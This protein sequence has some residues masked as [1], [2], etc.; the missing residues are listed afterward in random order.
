MASY[1]V[2]PCAAS[3][4]C[5]AWDRITGQPGDADHHTLCDPCLHAGTFAVQALP[6]DWY[7][8]EQLLPPGANPADS[9]IRSHDGAP[10]PLNL[11]AEALQRAIWWICTAWEDVARDLHRLSPVPARGV[12]PGPAVLRACT[13]LSPRIGN[14][15]DIDP[16]PMHD[17]P[18]ADPDTAILTAGHTYTTVPGYQ[19]VLDLTR[20]HARATAMLG[21]TSPVRHLPG[22]CPGCAG[23][24]L[25]QNQPRFRG[26]EQFV[27]CATCD[28]VRSYDEY[29]RNTGLMGAAA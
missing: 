5:R 2:G 24:D 9:T 17:Y 3:D 22:V 4:R 18:Y 21:L 8:L 29:A 7:D 27:Y 11:A 14:L 16:V 15:S 25:R 20:L 13:I 6:R 10:I 23:E 1:A 26:D 28:C 19:A 12:R